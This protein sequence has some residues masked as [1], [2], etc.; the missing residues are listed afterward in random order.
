MTV[1]FFQQLGAVGT[2]ETL[3]DTPKKEDPS[4]SN[5]G[6]EPVEPKKEPVLKKALFEV[7]MWLRDPIYRDRKMIRYL[8]NNGELNFENK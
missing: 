6:K 2:A 5:E 7:Q 1:F 3:D 4:Q 8:A